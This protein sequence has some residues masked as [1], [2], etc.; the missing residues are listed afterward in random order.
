MQ[1]TLL[2][3]GLLIVGGMSA[4]TTQDKKSELT[5]KW[6]AVSLENER[7]DSL[8]A[9]QTRFLDTFGKNTP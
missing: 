5:G 3:S 6:Q 4:C 1:K 8:M 9:E 7:L 2:L